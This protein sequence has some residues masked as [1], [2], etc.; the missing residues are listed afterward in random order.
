MAGAVDVDDQPDPAQARAGE[1]AAADATRDSSIRFERPGPMQLWGIDIM[2]GIE[3][4]NTDDGEVREAKIAT[5][6]DDHSRYCDGE[7]DGAGHRLGGVSGVRRSAGPDRPVAVHLDH[8][9]AGF[10]P[11]ASCAASEPAAAACVPHSGRRLLDTPATSTQL[12]ARRRSA[13]ALRWPRS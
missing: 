8:L 5:R 13:F 12:A 4:V 2:G 10:P 1:V 9:S 6:V 3:L 11:V 7:G